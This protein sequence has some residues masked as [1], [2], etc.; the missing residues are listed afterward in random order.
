MHLNMLSTDLI[1]QIFT[2]NI[3]SFEADMI[4]FIEILN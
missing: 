2:A 1:K 3:Y 4:Y